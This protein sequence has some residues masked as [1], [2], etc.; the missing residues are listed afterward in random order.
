M[1]SEFQRILSQLEQG[2]PATL[3][4]TAEGRTYLRKFLP[5][6]RLIL[7]GGGHIAQ[8]LCRFAALLDYAVT[9]A[10]DRPAFANS[11]RFP[12]AKQIVC[13]N[14]QSAIETLRIRPTDSV[15]V[16]TRGHRWD[17]DCLRKILQGELPSYLGMV[18]S[19]R[20]VAALLGLLAEEGYAA[21]ALSS[22]HAP[23]GLKIH[24][25]TPA[26]I[27]VS[28]CAELIAH[29]RQPKKETEETALPRTDTDLALLRFLAEDTPKALL[30][31]LETSGST[32]VEA[33]AVM[34]ADR[35][36]ACRGTIG[37]GCGEAAALREARQV[38][39][40]GAARVITVDMNNDIAAD[41]GMVC[42]GSM[43]VLIEPMGRDTPC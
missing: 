36:G 20:R 22:I 21:E 41:E 25:Q 43:R 3:T 32:P 30:L 33:G 15:C 11:E 34:A 12:D 28:I 6:E 24:A 14:F 5:Q 39:T 10:D 2:Q 31:V 40:S 16:L 7:L 18:G 1:S 17:G 38:M 27:A 26:E 29:R 8:A 37:G 42:G 4:R 9:V 23:I 19:S 35:L 13:D